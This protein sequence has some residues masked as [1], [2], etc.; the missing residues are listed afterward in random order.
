MKDTFGDRMKSNY[1]KRAQVSLLCRTPVIIR[2]DGKSFS[3]FCKRFER[4]YDEKLHAM[5]NDVMLYLCKNI[6]GA[7]FAERHSDEISILVTDYDNL[8]TD[9]YFDYEIQKICSIVA[10]MATSEFCRLLANRQNEADGLSKSWE[11]IYTKKNVIS[12]NEPWPIFDA[13]CFNVPEAEI[14]N[15]FW[16]RQR[17]AIR[18]SIGMLARSKFSHK[19]LVGKNTDQMQEML[20]SEHGI[21]WNDIPQ[22]Q[23]SGFVASKTGYSIDRPERKLWSLVTSPIQKSDLDSMIEKV[24]ESEN[25]DEEKV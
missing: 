15:Y 20:F 18:N 14:E 25:A 9:A 13:R 17:D 11:E 5:L 12:W 7:K 19:Q 2:V 3:K 16:W 8:N 23:K 24:F 22:G 21:N 10:S 6:Q 1:E 4:P